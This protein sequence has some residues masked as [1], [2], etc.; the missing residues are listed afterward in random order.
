MAVSA[1]DPLSQ[2]QL[3][4]SI[5]RTTRPFFPLLLR[6]HF[7]FISAAPLAIWYPPLAWGYLTEVMPHGKYPEHWRTSQPTNAADAGPGTKKPRLLEQDQASFWGYLTPRVQ[8]KVLGR[9]TAW[10][11]LAEAPA[12]VADPL[13]RDAMTCQ[14]AGYGQGVSAGCH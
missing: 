4:T 8:K 5:F 10:L 9:L 11:F 12:G 6:C 1:D 7:F 2:S 3:N 13:V 14:V